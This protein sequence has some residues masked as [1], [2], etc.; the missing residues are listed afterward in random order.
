MVT[1]CDLYK[2]LACAKIALNCQINYSVSNFGHF[3]GNVQGGRTSTD[4]Q[5]SLSCEGIC[6]P[7][8]VAVHDLAPIAFHSWQF[9]NVWYTVMAILKKHDI[10]LKFIMKYFF[11]YPLQIITASKIADSSHFDTRSSVFTFHCGNWA[12]ELATGFTSKTLVLICDL[13]KNLLFLIF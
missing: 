1:Q 6:L 13:F 10:V 9:R 5:H 11:L 2:N 12:S 8:G 3:Q 4:D 7:V